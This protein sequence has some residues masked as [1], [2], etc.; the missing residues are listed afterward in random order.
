VLVAVAAAFLLAPSAQADEVRMFAVGNKHRVQ[1]AVTY[2]DYRNKMA[3][4]MDAG[5][6]DRSAY[7]QAGVDDVASHLRPAD[8]RAPRRALVVFP[9]DVGLVNVLIGSRGATARAQTS[10][11]GAIPSLFEPYSRQVAYYADRFPGQP[12]VR[13]LF[14]ALTDTLYRSFYET[15]RDLAREH[16]VYIAAATNRTAPTPTRRPPPMRGTRPTCS[17]PTARCWCRTGRAARSRVPP[18]PRA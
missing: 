15:F 11:L 13:V 8:P 1:D 6:P 7:V 14:M 4:L 2:A 5:F 18:R 12:A 9:E 3:A 10:A 17:P 16:R